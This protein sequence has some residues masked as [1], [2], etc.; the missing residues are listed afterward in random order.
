MSQKYADTSKE[1]L[2]EIWSTEFGQV[3]FDKLNRGFLIKHLIYREQL[4]QFG[5]MPQGSQKLLDKL[6]AK[7]KTT[8]CLKSN[9]INA[10]T[11]FSI[12]AGTK[13]IREFKGEKHEVCALENG[14]EYRGKAY[15]SL[16]AIAKAITGTKWNGKV[17][18]GVAKEAR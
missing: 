14:F 15:G 3:P 12:Q 13:L 7:Y 5:A 4:K 11:A 10:S 6:V 17:F 1:A 16:S 9:D 18:F 2:A 8:K